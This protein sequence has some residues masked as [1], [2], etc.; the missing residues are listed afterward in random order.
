MEHELRGAAAEG[1]NGESREAQLARLIDEQRRN[2]T[3]YASRPKN[4]VA[5]DAPFEHE[6]GSMGTLGDDLIGV[7]DDYRQVRLARIADRM[8]SAFATT[9]VAERVR[10]A[11]EQELELEECFGRDLVTE[12]ESKF[13]GLPRD[14]DEVWHEPSLVARGVPKHGVPRHGFVGTPQFA[15]VYEGYR[16][17]SKTRSGRK[18]SGAD[19]SVALTLEILACMHGSRSLEDFLA[20]AMRRGRV[21]NSDRGVSVMVALT[22]QMFVAAGFSTQAI[23]AATGFNKQTISRLCQ[24]ELPPLPAATA[25]IVSDAEAAASAR[26]SEREASSGE[27]QPSPSDAD[28]R[29]T[30]D[31]VAPRLLS[32][33]IPERRENEARDPHA[34]HDHRR[35]AP[36]SRRAA[37]AAR[38]PHRVRD[39]DGIGDAGAA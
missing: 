21:P 33:Q 12:P 28:A 24:R 19:H 1:V 32:D 29:A 10:R 17:F 13:I 9:P 31:D 35:P 27:N 20:V 30:S 38:R 26:I 39:A 6:D 15:Q 3:R 8:P 4:S 23:M 34:V 18:P 25:L 37:P 5:Y 22:V 14:N 11:V 2:D 16:V 7:T 36:S